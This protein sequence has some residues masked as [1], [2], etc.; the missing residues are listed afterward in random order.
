MEDKIEQKHI[1]HLKCGHDLCLSCFDKLIKNT[2]PYCREIIDN[3]V[4]GNYGNIDIDIDINDYNY[5]IS[6]E[7]DNILPMSEL[8]Y[9]DDLYYIEDSYDIIHNNR[10]K[11]KKNH[12]NNHNHNRKNFVANCERES[13]QRH[14]KKWKKVKNFL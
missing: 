1:L 10:R 8:Y 11:K 14:K 4:E 7:I 2:C 5:D 13:H 12:N 9:I 3:K 6:T